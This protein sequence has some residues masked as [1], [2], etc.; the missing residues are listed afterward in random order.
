VRGNLIPLLIGATIAGAGSRRHYM[1]AM[2]AFGSMLKGADEGR[3][4]Q[5]EAAKTNFDGQMKVLEE[6][7]KA[8]TQQFNAI[9]AN[10]KATIAAK[11]HAIKMLEMQYGKNIQDGSDLNRA[12]DRTYAEDQNFQT[13][14]SRAKTAQAKLAAQVAKKSSD[15]EIG[16]SPDALRA[17]G[18]VWL[19]AGG[20]VQTF[21]MKG[22][23]TQ[24]AIVNEG[25]KLARELDIDPV[26]VP[27]LGSAF[28]AN[29]SSYLAQTKAKDAVSGYYKSFDNNI[30]TWREIAAGLDPSILKK[31]SDIARETIKNLPIQGDI[32]D[33]TNLTAINN[34]LLSFKK[35]I[36]DPQAVAYLTATMTVA[37][38]YSRIMSGGA[39]GS[40]AH[41]AEGAR[42]D[43]LDLIDA[44]LSPESREKQVQVLR[45][46]ATG[47]IRGMEA[48][49]DETKAR[50]KL[51]AHTKVI[52]PSAAHAADGW[53][54]VTVVPKQ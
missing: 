18:A 43:A 6:K 10:N 31:A 29:A 14:V 7:Q 12:I 34:A 40:I 50:M 20:K 4:E 46:E 33:S 11:E 35:S 52:E 9:V 45:A 1:G 38:D 3:K 36:G 32:N 22:R 15:N 13:M 49:I 8:F 2:S 44:G 39:S 27:S 48:Q 51:S 53:G 26:D 41:T 21:G 28:K 24:E 25:V 23:A 37:M 42:K 5:F 19:Q 47:K 54:P 17:E 16:L 30:Q